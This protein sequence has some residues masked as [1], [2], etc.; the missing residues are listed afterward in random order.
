MEELKNKS[1]LVIGDSI[2]DPNAD[3]PKYYYDFLANSE[4]LLVTTKAYSGTGYVTPYKTHKSILN[5]LDDIE[6]NEFDFIT[7]LAGTNDWHI[8]EIPLGKYGD[9]TPDTFYGG[10]KSVYDK[11]V[12]KFY[13][14]KIGIATP[15]NRISPFLNQY[16]RFHDTLKDY[17][18]AILRMCEDYGFT[19]ID[20]YRHGGFNFN[21]PIIKE[22]LSMGDG[23]HPNQSGQIRLT[24]KFRFLLK[25]L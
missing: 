22:K 6:S 25:S 20:L 19:S 1:W 15:L 5:S 3:V 9:R 17:V 23:L 11:L 10:L 21:I 7:V 4:G 12:N 14:S 24:S 16:N 8:G 13:N 18:D 2:S